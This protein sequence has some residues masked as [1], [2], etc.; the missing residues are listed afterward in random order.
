MQSLSTQFPLIPS[1]QYP[2]IFPLYTSSDFEL[3]ISWE[4]PSTPPRNG[5][6]VVSGLMIGY[7]G[8]SFNDLILEVEL[9]AS[10]EGSKKVRNMYAETTRER[11]VLISSVRHSLWN[12]DE[13]PLAVHLE[14]VNRLTHDFTSRC[15]FPFSKLPPLK[16]LRSAGRQPCPSCLS[17]ETP[18][19]RGRHGSP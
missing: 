9:G 14:L 7:S 19:S 12:Q 6:T 1:A 3:A 13:D 17:S 18:Q 11:E 2:F 4:V 15:V 16:R 10:L 8:G 5:F